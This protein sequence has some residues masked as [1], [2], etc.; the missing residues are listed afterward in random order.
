MPHADSGE[1]STGQRLSRR[2]GR[3]KHYC[4]LAG[5]RASLAGDGDGGGAAR[6]FR[7]CE[8]GDGAEQLRRGRRGDTPTRAG[9]SRPVS[10]PG[11]TTSRNVVGAERGYVLPSPRRAA[12][13]LHPRDCLPL[14]EAPRLR[15][16]AI[17]ETRRHQKDRGRKHISPLLYSGRR[18]RAF[19]CLI[20]SGRFPA[21][22]FSRSA[23][24]MDP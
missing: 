7:P 11:V 9:I 10:R 1:K 16:F 14:T 5:A 21:A 4:Q 20:S 23:G 15:M 6:H 12:I 22:S 2:R 3:K 19:S 18:P 8:R 17:G 13:R 24:P